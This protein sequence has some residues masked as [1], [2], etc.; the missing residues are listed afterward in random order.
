[1]GMACGRWVG[2]FRSF[3]PLFGIFCFCYFLIIISIITRIH[4][5][6]HVTLAIHII[7][8]ESFLSIPFF[9][10][11]C[12]SWDACTW[13][14]V[15]ILKPSIFENEKTKQN[16]L[17]IF[18]RVFRC[19][20]LKG[21]VPMA[22]TTRNTFSSINFHVQN[23][24]FPKWNWTTDA[25][26]GRTLLKHHSFRWWN[27]QLRENSFDLIFESLSSSSSPTSME[28]S[29]F[30]DAFRRLHWHCASPSLIVISILMRT[31]TTWQKHFFVIRR[32]SIRRC[33]PLNSTKNCGK[34]PKRADDWSFHSKRIEVMDG[35]KME[36][37]R[38]VP[39]ANHRKPKWTLE[40]K[41]FC[42]S[43]FWFDVAVAVAAAAAAIVTGKVN[44]VISGS[45]V[46]WLKW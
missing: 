40:R 26:A 8:V 37:V 18:V 45:F 29:I 3:L 33:Q 35:H 39:C 38:C 24:C 9:F 4:Q 36:S 27:T 5:S 25:R 13:T 44:L 43:L 21:H 34:I 17:N 30:T 42:F 19:C 31:Y 16:P 11:L 28:M 1:M 22:A 15:Y 20:S 6:T 14:A 12:Q 32:Y 10:P 23:K 41:V 46:G 2:W 7:F